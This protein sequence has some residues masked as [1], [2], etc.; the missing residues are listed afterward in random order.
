MLEDSDVKKVG[1]IVDEKIKTN[2]KKLTEN[3]IEGLSEVFVTKTEFN[4]FK[5]E[6]KREFAKVLSAVDKKADDETTEKQEAVMLKGK[7][8]R[9]EKW[10]GKIA[11]KVDV[12]LES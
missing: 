4:D 2:N 1:D 5:E 9:H 12:K 10:I 11:E 7:V 8:D 6:N 3:L